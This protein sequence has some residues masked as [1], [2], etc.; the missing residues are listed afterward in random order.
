VCAVRPIEQVFVYSL[1]RQAA[2]VLA[3][4]LAGQ[5]PI[6]KAISVVTSAGEAVQHAD[7]ICT[8]TTSP[9]PVFDGHWLR[10]GSH[11]NAI[12][13]FTPAMQEVDPETLRR[14]LVVVDSR[15]AALAE[16][17][18]LLVPIRAGEFGEEIVHAELGEIIAGTRPGRTGSE[19]ITYFKSVGV[20]VQDAV[21]AARA[22]SNAERAGLGRLIEL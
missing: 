12:G 9:T 17:G 15:Q 13:S 2:G 6:P 11:V 22:L 19:Q 3:G 18:D 16:A 21:A 5:G 14:S 20:A 1:D 4:E 10:P 7:I 8:A